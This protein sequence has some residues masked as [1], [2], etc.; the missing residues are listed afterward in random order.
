MYIYASST[1]VKSQISWDKARFFF[2]KR[3]MKLYSTEL[4]RESFVFHLKIIHWT[5][6]LLLLYEIFGKTFNYV[7]IP[8]ERRS[9][10][11]F[12]VILKRFSS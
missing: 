10:R 8:E 11:I 4:T 2:F 6:F 9:R 1:L 12:K 7:K 5:K 3:Q